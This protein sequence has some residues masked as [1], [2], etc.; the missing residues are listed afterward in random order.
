MNQNKK[1]LKLAA[2]YAADNG[3]ELIELSEYPD[4]ASF[5]E[6]TSHKVIYDIG[7]EEWLWYLL[8][9]DMTFTNSF[10]ACVLSMIGQKQFV[11]GFRGGDKVDLL[12]ER[13]GL[14]YRKVTSDSLQDLEGMA[15]IDYSVVSPKVEAYAQ[16]GADWV[17]NALKDVEEREHQPILD[18]VKL[19]E[20][21]NALNA[22][23]AADKAA[24]EKAK[25]E[26]DAEAARKAA[27]KE[28]ARLK[29]ER[30]LKTRIRHLLGRI[31]R[32]LIRFLESI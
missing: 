12:L 8:H 6:G 19:Q 29:E 16:A 10:H 25:E 4:N 14:L 1:L 18:E 26:K 28:A 11:S 22:R 27:E 7:V 17:L 2:D 21:M 20:R 5:P 23:I 24:E 3:L 13:F 15:P 32:A 9:S 31:R 30:K